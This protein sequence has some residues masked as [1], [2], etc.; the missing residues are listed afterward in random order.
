MYY[1]LHSPIYLTQIK[2]KFKLLFR[3]QLILDAYFLFSQGIMDYSM[4]VVVGNVRGVTSLTII[5]FFQKYNCRKKVEYF[6]RAAY[7]PAK[8]DEN[9]C[10]NQ[11]KYYK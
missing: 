2:P 3:E 1:Y 7:N 4:L 10:T 5:D 8:K 11:K 9:S 6:L